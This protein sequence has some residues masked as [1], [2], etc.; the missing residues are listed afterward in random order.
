MDVEGSV[1]IRNGERAGGPESLGYA[2]AWTELADHLAWL[3]AVLRRARARFQQRRVPPESVGHNGIAVFD[4]EVDAIL[5][6]PP[7]RRAAA[8]AP[9]LDELDRAVAERARQLR[10]RTAASRPAVA[11][12]LRDLG[13]AFGLNADELAI[14]VV[15]LAPEIHAEYGRLY[16]YLHNDVMRVQASGALALDLLARDDQHRLALRASLDEPARLFRHRLVQRA[17]AG[18]PLEG[19]LTLE[20]EVLRYL[21]GA[22]PASAGEAIDGPA[23]GDLVLAPTTRAAADL[24]VELFTRRQLAW[25]GVHGPVGGGRRSLAV[26]VARRL[27]MRPAL[28]RLG[29][30]D[31]SQDAARVERWLRAARLARACPVLDATGTEPA[32]STRAAREL[33]RALGD[34]AF[35]LAFTLSEAPLAPP[36]LGPELVTS[37]AVTA[38]RAALRAE[39]WHRFAGAQDAAWDPAE[40]DAV[41]AVFPLTPGQIHRAVREA[42]AL[43]RR[44]DLAAGL[45]AGLAGAPSEARVAVAGDALRQACRGQASHNLDRLAER[46]TCAH[47]FGDIVLPLD[48]ERQLRELVSAVRQRELVLERWRF[49]EKVS[50]APGLCVLF[51]GPSGTGKTMAA[52]IVARELGM[53]LYRIDLSRVVSKYIGETEK[54][55]EALFDEARRAH[56]VLFFDEADALLGK[57]SEVKDAHDRYANIEVAYLL[58]RIEAFEGVTVLAT[59]LRKNIDAAFLRRLQFC[60]EFPHPAEQL[61]LRIWRKVWPDPSV[62]AADVDLAFMAR[63]FELAGGHIR[64]VALKAAYLAAD[65]GPAIHM[66]HLVAATRREFQKLGRMCVD[67]EFG[68]YK[69]LLPR[70]T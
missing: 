58:Q 29:D 51:F 11:L 26:A 18:A 25:I 33:E 27:G 1:P 60:V 59:N 10:S 5:D 35:A 50:T 34:G 57:R 53:D 21:L 39:A 54:N 30:E 13:Q 52:G 43:Q 67:D 36:R 19:A 66:V 24:A 23:L 40:L 63:Q 55:L 64:N 17:A 49:G 56:A 12:P 46:V 61:R 41:A 70:R 62:L 16:A 65:E 45:A 69:H 32:R 20:G 2:S 15:C 7:W 68:S 47:D 8:P 31:A 9:E 28:L 14:C 6:A 38:P 37:I 3:D 22:S 48:E 44:R 4:A 42:T